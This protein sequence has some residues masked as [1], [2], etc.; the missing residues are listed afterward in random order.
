MSYKKNDQKNLYTFSFV[1]S[2]RTPSSIIESW[3]E[4]SWN[5][6]KWHPLNLAVSRHQPK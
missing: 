3:N 2:H 5:H 1:I 6:R 4:N